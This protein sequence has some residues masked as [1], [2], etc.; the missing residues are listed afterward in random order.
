MLLILHD[1]CSGISHLLISNNIP[2]F[3]FIMEY[4]DHKINNTEIKQSLLIKLDRPV[5]K[6]RISSTELFLFDNN[7]NFDDCNWTRNQNHLVCKRTLNRL[8]KLTLN[9]WAVFWVLICTVHSTVSP[10][11]VTYAFQS[12]YTL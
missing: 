4:G 11:H 2:S 8:A 9:D 10:Y 1:Q 3:P 12:E 6:T 7:K 5:L